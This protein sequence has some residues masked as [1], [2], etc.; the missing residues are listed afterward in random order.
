MGG[1]VHPMGRSGGSARLR[2]PAEPGRH[3]APERFRVTYRITVSDG[4]PIEEHARDIAIEQTVETPSDCIPADIAEAGIVGRTESITMRSSAPKRFDVA[5]SYRCDLT[6]FSIPQFLNVLFG[7]ISIKSGIK[8]VGLDL[9]ESL[10]EAFGGPLFGIEGVRST[11]GVF[12]RPLASTALKPVGLTP[13]RLADMAAAYARGGLDLIKEDHG[14]ADLAYH[15]FEE[16]VARCQEA[17]QEANARTGRN[18][19]FFPMISGGFDVIEAQVAFAKEQG[20]RGILTAPLLV[21]PDTVR[22]LS[23]R[24]GMIVMA[25]PTF[26]GTHFHDPAHG[27]TPAVLLGTLFRLIGADISVFPNAGGRFSFTEQECRDLADALRKPL[28]TVKP[29]FPAPAGGMKIDRVGGMAEAFG[30]ETVL[31]IG[32]ALMQ[33]SRDLEKSAAVFV[34]SIRNHFGEERREPRRSLS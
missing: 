16:R 34:E 23:R 20:V 2:D 33:Y 32:G 14:M 29:A 21:G 26:T 30:S 3:L 1:L 27:I 13:A 9:P 25:H 24:Y 28:G 10:T 17:V 7:N 8:I 5:I 19:L 22:V 6:G 31:L 18:A 4:R 11:L 15:P 12:G